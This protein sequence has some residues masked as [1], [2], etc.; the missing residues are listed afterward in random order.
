MCSLLVN[1]P[2]G[3]L[4]ACL[5]VVLGLASPLGAQSPSSR[6]DTSR[7]LRITFADGR[8][9]TS[10]LRRT[11]GMWTPE[12]PR[13]AGV[14]TSRNGLPLTTLD[15]KH[16]MD[17]DDVVL[18]VSLSYGGPGRYAISVGSVRLS[19]AA[20]V[21]VGGLRTYGVEPIRVSLVPIP[22]SAAYAPSAV[23]ASAQL[24]CAPSRS[25][26]MRRRIASL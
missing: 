22:A 14:E 18:T 11:G 20:S 6:T 21:E 5:G 19:A 7:A 24:F 9:V 3:S 26:R 15:L 16:E 17:G 8:I 4:A 25:G 1:R 13:I 2:A 23:S 12:F 10:P